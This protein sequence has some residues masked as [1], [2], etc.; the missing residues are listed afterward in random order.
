MYIYEFFFNLLISY[1]YNTYIILGY[2]WM[3]KKYN[4]HLTYVRKSGGSLAEECFAERSLF[5]YFFVL[6]F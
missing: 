1:I 3:I 5:M 2:N 4:T 6:F